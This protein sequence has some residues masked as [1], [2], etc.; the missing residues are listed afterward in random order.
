[1]VHAWFSQFLVRFVEMGDGLL[2][3][4]LASRRNFDFWLDFFSVRFHDFFQNQKLTWLMRR[5]SEW[6]QIM[7]A[8]SEIRFLWF[9]RW[10]RADATVRHRGLGK[11]EGQT[12]PPVSYTYIYIYYYT[13]SSK[14][15]NNLFIKCLSTPLKTIK[16]DILNGMLFG[17]IP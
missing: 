2:K 3:G 5:S 4:W 7:E 15:E 6:F 8:R 9:I 11:G 13:L 1:M 17:I 14:E 12:Q 10:P 16:I